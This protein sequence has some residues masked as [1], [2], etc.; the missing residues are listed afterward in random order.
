MDGISLVRLI[1]V[2]FFMPCFVDIFA[3]YA[4]NYDVTKMHYEGPGDIPGAPGMGYGYE[5]RTNPE[6]CVVSD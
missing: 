3:I 5:V 1:F 6:A 4:G 2:W